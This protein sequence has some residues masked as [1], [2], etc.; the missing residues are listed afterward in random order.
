MLTFEL[1]GSERKA[2]IINLADYAALREKIRRER[3]EA[4]GLHPASEALAMTVSQPVSGPEFFD[5]V[6]GLEGQAF[7]LY[8][9]VH[10]VDQTFTPELAERMVMEE[11]PFVMR[12]YVESK[13]FVNP[14]PATEESKEGS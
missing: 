1:D 7:M 13:I 8:R 11:H 12:L 2:R 4:L 10:A 9:A 6:V 14:T 5:M 3:V